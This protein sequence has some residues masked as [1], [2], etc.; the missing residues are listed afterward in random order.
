MRGPLNSI[1]RVVSEFLNRVQADLEVSCEV[2]NVSL[3]SWGLPSLRV[4]TLERTLAI[5]RSRHHASQAQIMFTLKTTRERPEA[6][7]AAE[8]A[9]AAAASES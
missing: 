5:P 9:A 4:F 2:S 3:D 1:G 8:A 7:V 6:A